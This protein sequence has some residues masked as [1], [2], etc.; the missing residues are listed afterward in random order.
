M[1]HSMTQLNKLHSDFEK[2]GLGTDKVLKLIYARFYKTNDSCLH[3]KAT[4]EIFNKKQPIGNA[5]FP[6]ERKAHPKSI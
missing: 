5:F 6:P 1:L 2:S 3:K 4:L